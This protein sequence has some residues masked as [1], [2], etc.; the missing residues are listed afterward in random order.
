MTS[1]AESVTVPGDAW[2]E[3]VAAATDAVEEL[4]IAAQ[5]S[6][7]PAVRERWQRLLGVLE[8]VRDVDA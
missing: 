7:R 6:R 4:Y 8:A 5:Y 2:R 3:L 1:A